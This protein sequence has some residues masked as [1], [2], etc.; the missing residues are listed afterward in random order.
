MHRVHE[1]L[2]LVVQGVRNGSARILQDLF[3]RPEEEDPVAQDRA[4]DRS[5]ELLAAER[6]LVR[7]GLPGEVVRR[8]QPPIALE[9]KPRAQIRKP[10]VKPVNSAR[11]SSNHPGNHQ[12]RC[13]IDKFRPA[14]FDFEDK[15]VESA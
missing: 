8:A 5:A 2:L 13:E 1:Q 12:V 15:L 14:V 7:I 6:N 11:L 10:A 9:D 4:A 3:G